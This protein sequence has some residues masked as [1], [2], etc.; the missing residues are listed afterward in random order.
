MLF[1]IVYIC[2]R[3]FIVCLNM[4]DDD[5][6]TIDT[7]QVILFIKPGLIKITSV[8]F[9]NYKIVINYNNVSH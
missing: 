3:A 8:F 5:V 6:F 9:I 1:V 2:R 4:T 7:N